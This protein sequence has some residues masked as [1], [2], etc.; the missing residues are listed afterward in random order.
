MGI[1]SKIAPSSTD[2]REAYIKKRQRV[3]YANDPAK[4]KRVQ[5]KLEALMQRNRCFGT[6][7]HDAYLRIHERLQQADLTINFDAYRW[8]KQENAF[9]TYA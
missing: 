2:I 4:T 7:W 9:A 5:D 3:L 6:D 8:F 1:L